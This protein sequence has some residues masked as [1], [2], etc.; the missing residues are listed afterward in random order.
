MEA[1]LAVLLADKVLAISAPTWGL[2]SQSRQITGGTRSRYGATVLYNTKQYD[3]VPYV[4]TYGTLAQTA[5]RT[6]RHTT[7]KFEVE[8]NSS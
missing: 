1:F 4:N 8:A 2:V 7:T 5:A 6:T 3:T